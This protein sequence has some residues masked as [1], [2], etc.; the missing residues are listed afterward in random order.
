LSDATKTAIG[1]KKSK[2]HRQVHP[3]LALAIS[4]EGEGCLCSSSDDIKKGGEN[5][6][7]ACAVRVE[8]EK[9]QMWARLDNNV[10][11]ILQTNKGDTA[12]EIKGLY[13]RTSQIIKHLR[14][15]SQLGRCLSCE[16]R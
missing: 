13:A 10:L 3:G 2:T 8:M 12:E 15:A 5:V 7:M 6:V 9:G 4:V 11:Q 16:S 14:C 1:S